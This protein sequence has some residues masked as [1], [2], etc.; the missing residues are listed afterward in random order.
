MSRAKQMSA[1][2][3]IARLKAKGWQFEPDPDEQMLEEIRTTGKQVGDIFKSKI[4]SD[5][6]RGGYE[7]L[8]E[9][10][11]LERTSRGHR[12][13]SLPVTEQ[14]HPGDEELQKKCPHCGQTIQ[15]IALMCPYCKKSV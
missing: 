9:Q 10:G 11:V 6:L 15:R 3:K 13:I 2:E 1:E 8:R 14:N 4:S 7:S 12:I 5:G